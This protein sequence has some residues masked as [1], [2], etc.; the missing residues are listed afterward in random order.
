MFFLTNRHREISTNTFQTHVLPEDKALGH[1]ESII[2]IA[3]SP[4]SRHVLT[5][6]QDTRIML[7][8]ITVAQQQHCQYQPQETIKANAPAPLRVFEGELGPNIDFGLRKQRPPKLYMIDHNLFFSFSGHKAKVLSICWHEDGN[9]F[10]SS[11]QDKT[12]LLWRLNMSSP[13]QHL[14]PRAHEDAVVYS[15][16]YLPNSNR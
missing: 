7:W 10:A 14:D 9:K 12:I 11:S 4:D 8:D 5:A 6:S 1:K 15:C 16:L 2:R 13:A 3:F